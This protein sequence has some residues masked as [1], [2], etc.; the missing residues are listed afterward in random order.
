MDVIGIFRSIISNHHEKVGLEV[1][2][3]LLPAT[4]IRILP[5]RSSVLYSRKPEPEPYELF[6]IEKTDKEF[7]IPSVVTKEGRIISD[8][9]AMKVIESKELYTN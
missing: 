2:Q 3:E 1:I 6:T 7:V 9:G 8:K 4:S 5:P